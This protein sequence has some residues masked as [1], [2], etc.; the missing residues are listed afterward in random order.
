M[1]IYHLAHQPVAPR[2]SDE[3]AVPPFDHLGRPSC[4]VAR[5]AA[6]RLRPNRSSKHLWRSG[7][8]PIPGKAC[9]CGMNGF[10]KGMS[11][12]QHPPSPGPR[13]EIDLPTS[14]QAVSRAVSYVNTH[15]PRFQVRARPSYVIKVRCAPK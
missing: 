2:Q 5:V 4:K 15:R 1:Y 12:T 3:R 8:N 14:V 7:P 13:S 10:I 11:T 9:V 6:P